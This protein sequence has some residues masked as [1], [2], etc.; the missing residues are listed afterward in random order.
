MPANFCRENGLILLGGDWY[1]PHPNIYLLNHRLVSA[2]RR[3]AAI[4]K[5]KLLVLKIS[6]GDLE[7]KFAY[8]K[9]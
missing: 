9:L 1:K 8:Q 5:Q 2:R 7:N 3:R 4:H 6:P